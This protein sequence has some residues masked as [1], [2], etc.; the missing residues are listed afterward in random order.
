MTEVTM[1]KHHPRGINGRFPP[2]NCHSRASTTTSSASSTPIPTGDLTPAHDDC[3]A[4]G[5]RTATPHHSLWHQPLSRG[6]DDEPS[7]PWRPPKSLASATR[8]EL[9]QKVR[10]FGKWRVSMARQPPRAVGSPS[11]PPLPRRRGPR[12]VDIN[13]VDINMRDSRRGNL[14]GV[15][16]RPAVPR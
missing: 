7:Q 14:I 8:R 1:P 4:L 15:H 5:L 10:P 12:P 3:V 2:A 11:V 9:S 13:M 16:K 6:T